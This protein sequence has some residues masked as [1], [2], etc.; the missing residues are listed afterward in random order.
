MKRATRSQAVGSIL[1]CVTLMWTSC[2]TAWIS[3]AE[4]IVAVLIPATGNLMAVVMAL[5]GNGVSAADLK[6][7]Q[8]AGSQAEADLQLLGSLIAEY[9]RADAT[10]KPGLLTQI[11]ALMTTVGSNLNGILPG[12]Q[13]KDAATQAKVTAVVGILVMEL[14]SMASIIPL[15]SANASQ[16]MVLME[17]KQMKK[18]APLTANEFVSSYNATMTAK[19]GNPNLDRAVSGLRIHLHGKLARL[20]SGGLLK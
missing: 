9:Q 4:Q 6:A 14:Q 13:I 15:V 5:K 11:Q 8:S 20:A 2:S 3:E 12:L 7:I 16:G 19:T 1:L 18:Q 10:A 17:E